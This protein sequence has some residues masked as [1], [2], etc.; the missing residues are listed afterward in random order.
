M[1]KTMK[2]L[3]PT[4]LAL[5]ISSAAHAG[6]SFDTPQGK[7]NI[8]GDVEFDV[9]ADNYN[10]NELSVGTLGIFQSKTADAT[11]SQYMSGRLLL[12]VNG[13][14]VL[15]NGMFAGFKLN[16]TWGPNGGTGSDDVYLIMGK[17][18]DWSFKAGHF[19]AYDL[20][21]A[22]QDTYVVSYGDA[23]YRA[24][25]GRGRTSTDGQGQFLVNKEMGKWYMELSTMFGDTTGIYDGLENFGGPAQVVKNK[26]PLLL[27]PVVAYNGDQFTVAGGAE[28]NAITDAYV[29]KDTREDVSDW[30]GYGLTGSW[31]ATQDLTI[32]LRGAYRNADEFDQWSAGTGIQYKNFYISYL[33]G[34]TSTDDLDWDAKTH[35]AYASYKIPAVMGLDNFDMYLAASWGDQE[36]S[37]LPAELQ[38]NQAAAEYGARVRFKYFF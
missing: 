20:S 30:M 34:E 33:Y 18:S 10:E 27:R 3:M 32:N 2:V 19:E 23:M 1:T 37:D 25:D 28:F 13:E 38:A 4:A 21:P 8:G 9:T 17:K 5:F 6:A 7:L 29:T 16:P 14:H 22:G 12:D 36:T 15:E 24:N 26:D 11:D 31:K 35:V